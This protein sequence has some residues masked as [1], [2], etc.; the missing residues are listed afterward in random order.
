MAQLTVPRPGEPVPAL[1]RLL[2]GNHATPWCPVL[3]GPSFALVWEETVRAEEDGLE[4][5]GFGQAVGL[6][7]QPVRYAACLLAGARSAAGLLTLRCTLQLPAPIRLQHG[8]LAEPHVVLW[9]HATPD[10]L[11][12]QHH[13]W[14]RTS[15][16]FPTSSS[17]G[18]RGNDLG[19]CYLYDPLTAWSVLLVADLSE[20]D[21]LGPSTLQGYLHYRA[22]TLHRW[23]SGVYRYG[24]GLVAEDYGGTVLPAGTVRLAWALAGRPRAAPPDEW[25]A[26]HELMDSLRSRAP[27]V[28]T[29]AP[30]F[31]S[32]KNV[33]LAAAEEIQQEGAT[34]CEVDGHVH[35]RAYVAGTSRVWGEQPGKY[36]LMTQVDILWPLLLLLPLHPLPPL[37]AHARALLRSLPA[38]FRPEGG[39]LG[40]ELAYAGEDELVD[41][42]YF[43]ENAL[44]KVPWIAH[45]TGD[46]VLWP[47]YRSSLRY[48][49]DLAHRFGYLFPVFY[50]GLSRRPRESATN[51]AAAGLYAYGQ[52]IAS[53]LYPGEQAHHLEEARRALATMR[54]VRLPLLYHE[55]QELAYAA[56]AA[57]ELR[58]RTGDPTYDR[59]RDDFLRAQLAMAYWQP[60]AYARRHGYAVEGGFQACS[61]ILYPAFKE[62][63]ESILPW[64]RILRLA[65]AHGSLPDLPLLSFLDAQRRVDAY[66]LPAHL[67]GMSFAT[68][69]PHIPL[70]NLALTEAPDTTGAVGQEVYGAGEVLWLYLMFEAVATVECREIPALCLDL[71][72][73]QVG[74]FPPPQPHVLVWNPTPDAWQGS[75]RFPTLTP[76]RRYRVEGTPAPA[77]MTGQELANT[78]VPVHLSPGAYALLTP[79]PLP[80]PET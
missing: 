14:H 55:P 51:Y 26:L 4:L 71:L 54:R 5:R 75:V 37:A 10:V 41:S 59:L 1:L 80:S 68:P 35:H 39:Y 65:L 63:V 72:D 13:E 50:Q 31:T 2:L 46:Q 21:W 40:N 79:R 45:R 61:S 44:I 67:P 76:S 58:A 3:G 6:D 7:G 42:W 52:V 49:E 38:Y 16:S 20:A 30:G 43:L 18:V 15:L 57:A 64:T 33:C 74:T 11:A 48:A 34:W 22:D 60:D 17:Q 62:N 69:C 47:L 25:E 78:G 24:L 56:L 70:E 73:L 66:F 32:W 8:R 28:R 19:A 53:H 12:R 23:E 77:V 27:V 29:W 36:E 9:V